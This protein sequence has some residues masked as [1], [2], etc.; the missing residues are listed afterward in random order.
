MIYMFKQISLAKCNY[1]IYDKKLLIIVKVFEKWH[2][3]CVDISMKKFIKIIND[4]QN[5]QIFMI[6]KQLN[7]RQARWVE[8]LSKFNFQIAY[9]SN[10]QDAKSNSLT[11]RS[12]NLSKSNIDERRQFQHKTILKT[13]HLQFDMIKIVNLVSMLTNDTW[14]TILKLTS[15]I[16]HLTVDDLNKTSAS[17]ENAINVDDVVLDMNDDSNLSNQS[18]SK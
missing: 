7:R 11:K 4:H 5:L 10:A 15:M 13:T 16:Y 1:K 8:F 18:N 12:Q 2:S 9:R 3:K 17:N 6:T 14:E